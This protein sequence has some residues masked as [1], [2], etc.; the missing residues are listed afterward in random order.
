MKKTLLIVLLLLYFNGCEENS[1]KD[2]KKIGVTYQ[3]PTCQQNQYGGQCVIYVRK[4][5]GNDYSKMKALCSVGDCGASL[6][7]NHWDLGY[8]KGSTPYKNSILVLGRGN[9]L[10]VGHVA[11]VSSV[12]K[13]SDNELTL[14]VHESNWDEDEKIDCSIS[15]TFNKDKMTVK[16]KNGTTQYNVEGF[17]YSEKVT[18]NSD[19]GIF[20]GAGSLVSPTEKTAGGNYDYAIMHP[21][22]PKNSTVVFQWFYDIDSCSQI[23]LF[24]YPN[25]LDVIVKAKAWDKHKIQKAFNVTLNNYDPSDLSNGV[26]LKRPDTNTPWTTLAITSKQPIGGATHIIA[27][28][29]ENSESFKYGNR[30]DIT[31]TL[32]D[33]T[34]SYYWTGTGSIISTLENRNFENAGVGRDVAVTYKSNNSLTS[35]QWLSSNNCSKLKIKSYDGSVAHINEIKIKKWDTKD[36]KST[37]CGSSLPC[38]ISAPVVGN[39]YI[40]KIKSKANAIKSGG[41]I[42]ECIE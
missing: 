14:N 5:F 8:G 26:T 2:N 33:V 31:P 20:D 36:W 27:R 19:A 3:K 21:H 15:Y 11:I 28:C 34:H 30:V 24:S 29:K 41:L 4:W 13:I 18:S 12:N 10:S 23:D 6:A 7:Y 16:R 35:F 42:A 32:V 17:I 22:S 1:S 37:S 40:L 9:G 39:Y 25:N 38:T